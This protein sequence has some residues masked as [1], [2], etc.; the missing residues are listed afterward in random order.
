MIG[1]VGGMDVC[2]GEV[3]GRKT[4]GCEKRNKKKPVGT[5]EVLRCEKSASGGMSV[6]V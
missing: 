6:Y 3:V 4:S 2:V 5:R 1:C